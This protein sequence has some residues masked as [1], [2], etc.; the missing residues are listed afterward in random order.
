MDELAEKIHYQKKLAGSLLYFTQ[1]F[2]KWRT[3][4]LFEL[5]YPP[6][7]QSHYID[8]CEALTKVID[9]KSK[10][11]I[12]NVPPRYGKS[13]CVI[14]FIAWALAQYPDS[15]NMYISYSHSLAKKQTQTIRNIITMSQYNY[16]FDVRL[17]D[18][19]QAKD[20]FETTREGSVYASGAGGTITG[21]GAGIK[22]C[23]RYGGCIV[24]DD[25]HKPDEVTSDT[26]REG[27]IDWYYNTLQSRLNTQETPIVFI[28]QRLH[29][30]DLAAELIKTG[31]WDTLVLPA[32]D[33][34]G[35]ALHPQMHDVKTLLRM[36]QESP[37]HF[38]SQY[39]Q[40]PQPSGGGIYKPEWFPLLDDYPDIIATFITADTAETDKEYNDASA[41]SFFGIYKIEVAG[42]AMPEMYGL[43]WIDCDEIRV[44]PKDLE[45]AFF[46]FFAK[47]M[48]FKVKPKL[49]AIER[50]STGVTLVSVL[51]QIQGLQVIDITR[52]GKVSKIE[53]FLAMQPYI[54][55]KQ[56]S[57][58]KD[59]KHT[60]MCL[61]HMRKITANDSHAHD[62]ICDT[63]S[64]AV[65]MALID[66][67]IIR[68]ELPKK[69]Y[70]QIAKSLMSGY[71]QTERARHKAYYT[72]R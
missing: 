42:Q 4:R 60:A 41:F 57:L 13:E 68:K 34:S 65:K 56:V 69:D 58:L 21:R 30:S 20:N 40:D 51:K 5:S 71:T 6:G 15:N 28:G 36:Q 14:H 31:E 70:S 43:H 17:K 7:R 24:I 3:G 38:A 46:N 26:M 62:D 44:E 22:N 64:D 61:E 54:A 52:A 53:R 50:K 29:E 35:N 49:A 11:L 25:I 8:I 32:L 66:K 39:Q 10:R 45:Q 12:I 55:S 16:Y 33:L 27:I 18:D 23:N 9:G 2:F 19:A 37:Y 72:K 47:C 67:T 59:A 48:Q 63:L 1:M